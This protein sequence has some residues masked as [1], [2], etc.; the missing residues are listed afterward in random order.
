VKKIIII[1]M[2]QVMISNLM[3]QIGN[4][5]NA[6]IEENMLR[7][8]ILNSLRSYKVKFGAEYGNIV[9]ACDGSDCWRK[10][11]FPY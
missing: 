7:H 3:M 5:T 8:M 1:D 11:Y 4:H 9:I 2:N 10:E 6:K